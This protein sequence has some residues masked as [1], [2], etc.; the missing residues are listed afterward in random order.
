MTKHAIWSQPWSV[1]S[2]ASQAA[3]IGYALSR[4]ASQTLTPQKRVEQVQG[5]QGRD[6]EAEDVGAAHTRSSPSIRR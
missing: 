3:R 2:G 5:E 6:H 4:S 1:I